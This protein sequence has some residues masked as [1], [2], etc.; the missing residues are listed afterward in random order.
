MG[1]SLENGSLGK[2][3]DPSGSYTLIQAKDDL[4]LSYVIGNGNHEKYMNE[5]YLESIIN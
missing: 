3:N 1:C 5:K 4:S 2:N